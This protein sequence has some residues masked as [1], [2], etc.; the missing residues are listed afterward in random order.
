MALAPLALFL[1]RIAPVTPHSRP[2]LVALALVGGLSAP[3]LVFAWALRVG[4]LAQNLTGAA[5]ITAVVAGLAYLTRYLI[6]LSVGP[7]AELVERRQLRVAAGGYGA[8][9]ALALGLAIALALPGLWMAV[10]FAVAAVA[11]AWLNDR[12]PLPMLRR[13]AAAFATTA[14][15]R[16]VLSPVFQKEGAWPVLNS[17]I[18]AY[19]LP[20]VLLAA[21]A[22]FLAKCK[23]DRAV[24]TTLACAGLMGAIYLAFTI[25]HGFHGFDL[26]DSF[27][28]GLG[29]SGLYA[30]ACLLAALGLFVVRERV[31]AEDTVGLRR[32]MQGVNVLGVVIT[33]LLS[34]LLANPWLGGRI[35]GFPVV[36]SSFVGFVLPALAMGALAYHGRTKPGWF[37][38]W[39]T[40]ANR[41]LAIALGYLFALA[42]TRIVFVGMERFARAYSGQGEQYAYSAVTL[43]FG[44]LL[45]VIGFRLG[46]R[47]TRLASAAFVTLAVLKVFLFDL[48]ELEGL[49]RAL[50]FIGLGAVLIGIGLAY[51][52]LLFDRKPS[53]QEPQAAAA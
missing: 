7:A 31:G 37:P 9:A 5:I 41:N 1:R 48:S 32:V 33:G 47:P 52:R 38:N 19:A 49:L 25:R 30:V 29:E 36:D 28:V 39:L 24:K 50:S 13:V 35:L 16:A 43:V 51:Q 21:A 3:V 45:L 17:Y 15:L 12:Q 4:G 10:G 20:A 22:W 42:Q 26:V 53:P 34:L 2:V 18:V 6:A 23:R 11:V 27:R 8:G 46:S 44:V 14:I 40:T